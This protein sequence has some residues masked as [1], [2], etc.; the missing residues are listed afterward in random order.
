M[1]SL[2]RVVVGFGLALVLGVPGGLCL[3]RTIS[4][5]KTLVPYLNFLRNLSPLAWIPFAVLW[6]GIGDAPAIFLIF[7][8]TVF[9]LLL[10]S[11]AAVASVP[12]VFLRVAHEA[13]FSSLEVLF[14]VVFPSVLPQLLTSIR[15]TAGI[16]WVVVVPA[17]M[18][19]GRDGL[20]FAVMDA[21]N[22]LRTDLLV[23]AMIMIGLIGAGIDSLFV[24]LK[25]IPYV[26]WGY[27][28]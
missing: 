13:E 3:G 26:R 11:T 25:K 14:K 19:A 21:R 24:R 6:F 18:L 22:G 4:M 10:A 28:Q 16:A 5:R 20:G 2:F 7:L 23:V 17:E 1:A 8:A 15:V 27:E 9:P 12:S